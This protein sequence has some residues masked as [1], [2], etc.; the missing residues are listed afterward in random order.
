MIKRT[1]PLASNFFIAVIISLLKITNRT[2]PAKWYCA[3][4][5]YRVSWRL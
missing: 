2:H 3:S 4:C 5:I 1:S